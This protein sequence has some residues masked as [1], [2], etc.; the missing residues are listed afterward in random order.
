MSAGRGMG[1]GNLPGNIAT[2]A[3]Y[4]AY[5]GLGQQQVIVNHAAQPGVQYATGI[6]IVKILNF[7]CKIFK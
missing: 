5:A 1:R 2:V 7:I 3:G 4:G 6:N